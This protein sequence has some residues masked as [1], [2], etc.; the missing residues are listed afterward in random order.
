[1]CLQKYYFV[2]QYVLSVFCTVYE[3]EDR[4]PEIPAAHQAGRSFIIIEHNDKEIRHTEIGRYN[5]LTPTVAIWVQ[6]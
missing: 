5:P 3:I 2:T 4:L 1:M 6:L